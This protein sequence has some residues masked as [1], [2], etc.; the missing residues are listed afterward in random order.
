MTSA[1][2]H[3]EA[4]TLK[5]LANPKRLEI[6][7]LLGQRQLTA[8]EIEQMTGFPQANLSQHLR[9]L[10]EGRIIVAERSGKNIRYRLTH[11]NFRR[12]AKIL[13]ETTTP[14]PAQNRETQPSEVQD[15]VCGMWV[16]PASARWQN[17]YKG[18]TFFFCASGC[19]HR[20]RK[21]PTV[22]V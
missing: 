16:E 9:E 17:L 18:A 2:F 14:K 11:P 12:L 22:Y 13:A 19:Y 15:P 20:F 10:K 5:A 7:Y 1:V 21:S 4:A 3:H 6:V 8:S